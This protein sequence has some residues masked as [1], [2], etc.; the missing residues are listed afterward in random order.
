MANGRTPAGAYG[1]IPGRNG[2]VVGPS[3]DNDDDDDD[4]ASMVDGT[5]APKVLEA[6][7]TGHTVAAGRKASCRCNA[8]NSLQLSRSVLKHSS[9]NNNNNKRPRTQNKI[10]LYVR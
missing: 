10:F 9:N 4:G 5:A 1:N 7:A 3:N 6:D 2:V 8:S